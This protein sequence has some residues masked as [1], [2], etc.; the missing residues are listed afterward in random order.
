VYFDGIRVMAN[1]AFRDTNISEFSRFSFTGKWQWSGD[2][3]L[4]ELR[5]TT[6]RP[7]GLTD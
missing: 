5:I 3:Y 4:D 7:A 1:L 2:A 6:N